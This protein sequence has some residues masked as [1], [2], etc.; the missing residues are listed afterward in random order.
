LSIDYLSRSPSLAH[1]GNPLFPYYAPNK[2]P[3]RAPL[4]TFSPPAFAFASIA[5]SV[6]SAYLYAIKSNA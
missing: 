3:N 2:A 4:A 5:L 6:E 1:Y